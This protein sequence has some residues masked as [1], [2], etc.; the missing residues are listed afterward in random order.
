MF[1]LLG[2]F[3]FLCRFTIKRQFTTSHQ[4]TN[5]FV[6]SHSGLVAD[7]LF[8]TYLASAFQP[9]KLKLLRKFWVRSKFSEIDSCT[10]ISH[11][12]W[13]NY[14]HWYIDSVPRIW[15]FYEAP[16]DPTIPIKLLIARNLSKDEEKLLTCLLPPN[17]SILKVGKYEAFRARRFYFLPFYSGNCSGRLPKD[18]LAF[19]QGRVLKKFL[20]TES[21]ERLRIFISRA[22]WNR[23]YFQNQVEVEEFLT[24]MGFLILKL[25]ALSLPE[26]MYYFYNAEIVIGSHGAGLTN[27]LYART[28]N[29]LEIFHQPNSILNHY[30]DLSDAKGLV[31]SSVMLDGQH[32]DDI[33]QCPVSVLQEFVL[34]VSAPPDR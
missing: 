6:Q 3:L 21:P 13:D 30:R 7:R 15:A 18:Y 5:V 20:I 26:Q 8:R 14:Y 24:S 1:S 23:R 29:V 2:I 22:G 16:P 31:Y 4:F 11:G 19:Y 32:K 9:V 12:Q 25:E 10:V 33:V 34:N 28:C 27:L 17:V